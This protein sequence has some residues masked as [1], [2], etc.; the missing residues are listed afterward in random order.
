MY[1]GAAT[2]VEELEPGEV[3]ERQV[4]VTRHSRRPGRRSKPLFPARLVVMRQHEDAGQRALRAAKRSHSRRRSRKKLRPLTLASTGYL[5]VLTSLSA[6]QASAAEVLAAYR[7]RWQVEVAFKRLKSGLGIDRLLARDPAMARSWLLSHLILAL[8]IEDAAGEVLDN[9]PCAT[10]RHQ[11]SRL[12]VAPARAAARCPARGG[13][14]RHDGRKR[15]SPH[16]RVAGAAHLRPAA[17]QAVAGGCL[18]R[19]QALCQ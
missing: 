13:A 5:M 18:A 14:A 7:L 8:L 11:A 17:A 3:T 15:S 2:V 12:A 10:G 16:G 19:N 4:V 1:H 9:P 6:E